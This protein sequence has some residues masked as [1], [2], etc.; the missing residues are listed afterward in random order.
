MTRHERD[1]LSETRAEHDEIPIVWKLAV[2]VAL[3]LGVSLLAAL[4]TVPFSCVLNNW[5]QPACGILQAITA[6]DEKGASSRPITT[7][8]SPTERSRP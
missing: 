3:L 8:P 6:Q 4:V 5:P 7:G 1:K 2:G